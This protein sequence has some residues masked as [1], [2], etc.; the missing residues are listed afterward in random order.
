MIRIL[1]A[2]DHMIVR[3]GLKLI[4]GEAPDMEVVAEAGSGPEALGIIGD[5][6]CDLVLLDISMP[7]SNGIE[8]LKAIKREQP[9]L[10]VLILSMYPEEQYAIRAFKAGASGYLTKD[11]PGEEL[12]AA[13]RKAFSGGRY[14]SSSLAET[15]AFSLGDPT[16]ALPHESLSDREYQVFLLIASG[17]STREIADSMTLS[18]KTVSTYRSRVMKKM[19]M[20]SNAHLTRYAV[21][22]NLID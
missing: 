10:P 8:V 15:I 4:L 21:L 18:V 2:D 6:T 1:L 19:Q 13:I 9:A 20:K 12:L 5:K 11:G 14:I 17:K 16:E 7:G 3:E 22:Q